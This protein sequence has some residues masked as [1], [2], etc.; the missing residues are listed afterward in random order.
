MND[1]MRSVIKSLADA[2]IILILVFIFADRIDAVGEP[3]ARYRIIGLQPFA[4]EWTSNLPYSE[5][6]PML[7]NSTDGFTEFKEYHLLYSI[8]DTQSQNIIEVFITEHKTMFAWTFNQA[9]GKDGNP[10]PIHA[11]WINT[12]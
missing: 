9:R 1:D 2:S 6:R 4:F 8:V 3:I 10:H 11:V 7:W 5:D 12:P